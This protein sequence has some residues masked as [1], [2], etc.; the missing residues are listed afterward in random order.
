[1][2]RVRENLINE[3]IDKSNKYNY[4]FFSNYCDSYSWK[5]DDWKSFQEKI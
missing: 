1:M 5:N 4:Y 3:K 2:G